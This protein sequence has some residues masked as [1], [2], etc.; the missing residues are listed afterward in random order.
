MTA[1][2]ALPVLSSL[3]LKI[4]LGFAAVALATA[5]VISIAIPPIVGHGFAEL[6]AGSPSPTVD[7]GG[8]GPGQ[9]RGTGGG[10]PGNPGNGAGP[11]P[12]AAA[13]AAQVQQDTTVEL[14]LIAVAAAL[15]ASAAGFFV[16]GRMARPLTELARASRNVAAGDLGSRSGL[17]DRSDEFGEVGRSF[18][19]MATELQRTERER[20]RFVQDVVHELR[21]P[22]TV[23]EGTAGAMEEGIFPAEPRHLRTIREQTQLLSRIVDD[24]RTIGL[25]EAGVLRLEREPVDAGELAAA[26]TAAFEARAAAQ[27]IGLI[28]DVEPGCSMDADP[29]RLRQVLAALVDN[30]LRHTP[31]G[32]AVSIIGRRAEATVRLAVEDGGPGIAEEDLPRIFDRLY[33]ADP[34]RDRR[35]G[36]SGL[37]LSIVRAVVEAH[38]GQVGAENRA[39][40]GARVWFE[41]PASG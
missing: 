21:T 29:D 37:G 7:A 39:S 8:D 33:Q 40:G 1:R 20:Q 32:G 15:A 13:H 12:N 3:R 14:I 2:P 28:A 30:G 27:G 19:E 16:A 35:T 22:L 41:V 6:A 23:I 34:S 26:T 25:A 18:D 36:T 9:G 11:G 24:L 4:A 38:G 5:A 31:R 10:N 17:D